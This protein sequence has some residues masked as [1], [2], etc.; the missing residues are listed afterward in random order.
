MNYGPRTILVYV[1]WFQRLRSL[2]LRREVLPL[3]IRTQRYFTATHHNH[4]GAIYRIVAY[5][6]KLVK[7][8]ELLL[9]LGLLKE[10]HHP[11][12][13]KIVE[14]IA[15]AVLRKKSSKAEE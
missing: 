5:P 15:D 1:V 6:Q 12:L 8:E 3:S 7:V 2:P 13:P 4:A 9:S 11:A 14:I 10:Q